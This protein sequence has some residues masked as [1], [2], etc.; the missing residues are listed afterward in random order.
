MS[1]TLGKDI[2][3]G[4]S[5]EAIVMF[6]V[7]LSLCRNRSKV[8]VVRFEEDCVQTDCVQPASTLVYLSRRLCNLD[9]HEGCGE[10][11]VKGEEEYRSKKASRLGSSSKSVNL[12]DWPRSRKEA[13]LDKNAPHSTSVDSPSCSMAGLLDRESE[14]DGSAPRAGCGQDTSTIALLD[15]RGR[16]SARANFNCAMPKFVGRST[17][18]RYSAVASVSLVCLP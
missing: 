11:E 6:A 13:Q 3:H 4:G 7:R 14:T 10:V 9:I 15:Q 2:G 12:S 17:G 1:E 18:I 8:S 5:S 16:I